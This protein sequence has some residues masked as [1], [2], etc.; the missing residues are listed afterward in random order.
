MSKNFSRY[1]LTFKRTGLCSNPKKKKIKIKIHRCN[2]VQT[3]TLVKDVSFVCIM[4]FN[5]AN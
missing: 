3:S 2:S 4:T 5:D 1:V